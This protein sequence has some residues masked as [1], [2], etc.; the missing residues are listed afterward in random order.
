MHRAGD[1]DRFDDPGRHDP[2]RPGSDREREACMERTRMK[3]AMIGAV[4]TG[5]MIVALGW[6]AA[7]VSAQDNEAVVKDRQATMK[8]QGAAMGSIKKY[9]DGDVDQ[10]TA[11]KSADDLVK[12]AQS[13]P[14]K[15]T[16]GTS[17]TDFPGKSGAKP[18]IWSEMDKFLAAQKNMVSQAEKLDVA[19]K[20]GDKKAAAE[21]YA[22]TGKDGCGGCHNTYREKLG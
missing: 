8:A 20:S 19:V 3:K 18:I 22:T 13:L 15:F 10:A 7:G 21:Q 9:L 1:L 6:G 5:A 4:A 14:G 12:L 16:Q 11:A 2:N 17:T